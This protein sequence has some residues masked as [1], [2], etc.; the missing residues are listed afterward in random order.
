MPTQEGF[1]PVGGSRGQRV[2]AWAVTPKG[3]WKSG[4]VLSGVT[5]SSNEGCRAYC[6]VDGTAPNRSARGQLRWHHWLS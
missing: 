6:R 1:C 5:G 3:E 2:A 4:G